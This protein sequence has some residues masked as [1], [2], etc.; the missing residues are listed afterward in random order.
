LSLYIAAFN[1]VTESRQFGKF[2]VSMKLLF[3]SRLEVLVIH[4]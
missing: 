4:N 2:I 1:E 3:L